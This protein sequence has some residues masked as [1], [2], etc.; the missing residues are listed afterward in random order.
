[1]KM[2]SICLSW[3]G[4]QDL[5]YV[6]IENSGVG[7]VNALLQSKYASAFDEVHLFCDQHRKEDTEKYILSH[8]NNKSILFHKCDLDNPTDYKKIY[9]IV[10]KYLKNLEQKYKS[11][12][13]WHFH[14]S[15]GTSQMSSI[16]L[17]LGKTRHP[18]T[19]Y[20]SY[21]DKETKKQYVKILDIPFNI[22][23][24]FI[25]EL[26]KKADI[27]LLNNWGN[28]PEYLC[29]IH[30]SEI[31][32]NLLNKA[33]KIAAHY[34]PVLI[35]GETGTGKELFARAIHAS[36]IRKDKKIMVL[37]CSAIQETTANA[38]LFGWSK[39]AW[40]GSY[41]E[42]KGLFQECNGGTLFLDEIGDLNIE[43]Q[44]RILR[45]L[46]YGEIQRV[47]DGKVSTVDVRVIA[48]TNKNLIKMV[49]E[50]TF[51]EDLFHR[52][53]VG[54]LNLPPLRKRKEDIILLAE[55]FLT[56]INEKFSR[57]QAI[58]SYNHKKFSMGTK[59]FMVNYYWP[60]NIRELYHTIER[61]CIWSDS[62]V[63]DEKD[64]KDSVVNFSKGNYMNS[65]EI[66]LNEPVN[67][68]EIT[69]NLKKKYIEKA[70]EV[71]GKNKAQAAKLL[72]YKNYQTLSN[73]MKSLGSSDD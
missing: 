29:I 58:Y 57:D 51:R 39:G 20:Q 15:P 6:S 31:M 34:V 3:I 42:G 72:G 21:Y 47:G 19:L 9:E 7:P 53:N 26:K 4:D 61:A 23:M 59:N 27:E 5:N 45:T 56:E 73:H 64:F 43:T 44:T 8:K 63:I 1:M 17:L 65:T 14:T 37:N 24:E 30:K 2:K 70:L 22:E 62:E 55:H 60:G 28:I 52:I 71:T 69:D 40:T 13:N 49:N 68:E 18:A 11:Q 67:L 41:G 48:A 35:L 10:I 36:S 16:W 54:I 38:T 25:P 12:I 50:G 46:Q 66:E 32:K 33:Y